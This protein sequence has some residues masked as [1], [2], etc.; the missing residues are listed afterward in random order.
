M[1]DNA[2]NLESCRAEHSRLVVNVRRMQPSYKQ[3]H[4][5]DPHGEL[6]SNIEVRETH[7][8]TAAFCTGTQI[9]SVAPC[10]QCNVYGVRGKGGTFGGSTWRAVV[11]VEV[12]MEPRMDSIE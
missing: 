9:F 10:A 6:R 4:A 8:L 1:S 11:R 2:K 3:N 12:Q 7:V 5:T